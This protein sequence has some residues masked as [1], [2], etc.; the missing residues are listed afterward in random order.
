M[1]WITFTET[2]VLEQL[3]PQEK[4]SY[5]AVQ[6]SNK[7]PDVVASVVQEIRGYVGVKNPLAA[8]ATIPPELESTA[9]S[10]VRYRFL[11]GLPDK[12]LLTEQRVAEN[13]QALTRLRA[14]AKGEFAISQSDGGTSS[15]GSSV[16]SSRP[17]RVTSAGLNG[18]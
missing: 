11:N 17:T 18:L 8:G 9:I 2:D 1:S 3:S 13:D 14:V 12:R 10:I 4:A 15:G 16:I 5:T 7:L 6:G